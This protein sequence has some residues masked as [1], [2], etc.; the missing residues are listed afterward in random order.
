MRKALLSLAFGSIFFTSAAAAAAWGDDTHVCPQ[1]ALQEG[2][3]K[4]GDILYLPAAVALQYCNFEEKFAAVGP[5]PD[6]KNRLVC[7]Y[8]GEKIKMRQSSAAKQKGTN[9]SKKR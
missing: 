7:Q 9:N 6:R 1:D 2:K 3:C 5:G 8:S 4:K